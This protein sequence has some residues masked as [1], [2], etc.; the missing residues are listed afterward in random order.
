M[1]IEFLCVKLHESFQSIK[2]IP[3]RRSTTCILRIVVVVS[4]MSRIA[5]SSSRSRGLECGVS[6]RAPRTPRDVL[7]KRSGRRAPY[8]ARASGGKPLSWCAPVWLNRREAAVCRAPCRLWLRHRRSAPRRYPCPRA[9]PAYDYASSQNG[10][11]VRV[12]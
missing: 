4:S 2:T 5:E 12:A 1:L 3:S 10:T 11:A 7:G 8:R 6:H 9:P